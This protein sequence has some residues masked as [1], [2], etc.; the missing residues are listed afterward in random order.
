MQNAQSLTIYVTTPT[1]SLTLARTHSQLSTF[2][3]AI[4]RLI[5]VSQPSPI[6]MLDAS[7]SPS[8]SPPRKRRSPLF[9]SL[10]R[11]LSPSKTR[12]MKSLL[13]AQV[14]GVQYDQTNISEEPSLAAISAYLSDLAKL[15]AVR[16]SKEWNKFFAVKNSEDSESQRVERRIKRIRSDPAVPSPVSRVDDA[17]EMDDLAEL[18]ALS[19]QLAEE[20]SGDVGLASTPAAPTPTQSTSSVTVAATPALIEASSITSEPVHETTQPVEA[21]QIQE[22]LTIGALPPLP[23]TPSPEPRSERP[24]SVGQIAF[25]KSARSSRIAPSKMSV[26]EF[27]VLHVLGKGC[28]GKVMLVRQ[29]ESSK[30]YA[31]KAIHKRK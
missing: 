5:P 17:C 26:S 12:Q 19:R 16:E 4:Q 29:K 2:D 6:T 11:T 24:T 20:D 27:D 3:A 7:T 28:A 21:E 15:P 18:A 30:L 31:M 22:T 10:S 8:S 25:P 9:A 13:Q 23:S 1:S 14:E